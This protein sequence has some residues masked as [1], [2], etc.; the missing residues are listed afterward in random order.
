[1]IR[2]HLKKLFSKNK[3][4]KKKYYAWLQGHVAEMLTV[5]Y[6][7]LKFY[8]LIERRF[9][10]PVGEIDLIFSKGATL[11]FVEVKLR[12]NLEEAAH[13]ISSSQ[14]HRI[15]RAAKF[16]L[17]RSSGCAKIRFDV[18]LINRYYQLR[19]IKNAFS[20]ESSF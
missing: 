14:R 19:H 15:V 1:M 3:A 6:F 16:F 9:K 8:K 12:K 4:Y 11:V 2:T 13:S 18:V 5:L 7:R 20:D 10:S 17:S